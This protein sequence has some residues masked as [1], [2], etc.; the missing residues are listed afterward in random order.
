[1]STA[2]PA[3]HTGFT[4][5]ASGRNNTATL[6]KLINCC[7]VGII[8]VSIGSL[9]WFYGPCVHTHTYTHTCTVNIN[10]TSVTDGV[11]GQYKKNKSKILF[12]IIFLMFITNIKIF[13]FVVWVLTFHFVYPGMC[14]KIPLI[15]IFIYSKRL[16]MEN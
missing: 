6:R 7:L 3:G 16:L 10:C 14:M 1:M 12:Q 2:R 13:D 8:L 5:I 9:R 11:S 15:V 4:F